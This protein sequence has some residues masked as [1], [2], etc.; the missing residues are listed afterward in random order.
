MVNSLEYIKNTFETIRIN[1]VIDIVIVSVII[2][3]AVKFIKDKRAAKLLIGISFLFA[4]SLLSDVFDMYALNFLLT[5]VFEVGLIALIIVFQPELRSALEKVGGTSMHPI[6]MIADPKNTQKT[7]EAIEIISKSAAECSA[8]RRGAL[9]VIE[10]TTKLGDIVKEGTILKSEISVKLLNNIFHDKAPLHDGAVIISNNLI[11]AA[12]C[13][14]PLSDNT[15]ALANLGTRHRAG[16]GISENSDAVVVIVS[17]ETG[18]IS[19]AVDGRLDRNYNQASLKR[20]LTNLLTDAERKKFKIKNNK[21][22]ADNTNN[23]NNKSSKNNKN[24]QNNK[25]KKNKKTET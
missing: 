7:L 1:D 15:T 2:Y 14:L 5:N 23:Q 13:I 3:Y 25:N 21:N 8:V 4:V 19:L 12:G 24:S 16:L 6:S 17:E 20:E 9:I 10:R 11:E 22:N 18:K